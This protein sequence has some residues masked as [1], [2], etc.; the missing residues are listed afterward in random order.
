MPRIRFFLLPIALLLLAG[1]IPNPDTGTLV[2]RVVDE[3]DDPLPG[4][5]VVLDGT[6]LGAATDIDGAYRIL[7]VPVGEY[8]VTVS[9]VGYQP[10]IT[11]KVAIQH[12]KTTELNVA[13]DAPQGLDEI[14]VVYERPIIQRDAIG[15]PKVVKGEQI[16]NLPIRGSRND[17]ARYFIDGIQTNNPPPTDREGYAAIVE[18]NFKRP[19]D[20]PL[21]TFSIDV[22]AA[23]YA[24]VRR[25]LD[26]GALPVKDAVRIEELIN[27][28]TYDY[29]DPDGAHPFAVVTEVSACP[30]A[31][32]HRLV[33]IGLQGERI[34]TEDLPPSNLVF[35]LDV[36]G[37]MDSPDKLPL[38][39]QGF[40]LLADNL[41]AQDRVGIVV[42]AGA[43][44]VV[45]EPTNDKQQ[46][47]AALD[48]L[49]AGGSTAGGEGIKL[50]YN[51]ARTHFDAEKNNRVILA[52]DGD[53]NVGASSDAEMMRLIE[54]QRDSGVF[55][56]VLGFG[57]GNLQDSKMETI[58]DHG[59][60]HY[61]YIDSINEARKV[62]VNEMGGTLVTIAKDVK[63]QVEFNPAHVAAYRLIGYENRVLADEDFNDD[64]KDAGELGAGHSVTALYEIVPVGVEPPVSSVD[65]LKYQAQ[66]VRGDAATSP[67]LL[68][69]KLRYKPAQSLPRTRSGGDTSTLL[70]TALVDR[71]TALD[72]A[73]EAFRFSASVAEFG[74]LLRDSEHEGRASFEN[75]KMLA[76]GALGADE[77]GYRAEFVRLIDTA[78]AL[79]RAEVASR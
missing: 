18:N 61:A 31:P 74:L 50:A 78:D 21:S 13:L 25:F 9:F 73:S 79:A 29:P 39:K 40:R 57:T 70:E 49:Q 72:A 67:E 10:K 53:F 47:L 35:L 41:R 27:Y 3:H 58:A 55:L 11:E 54:A 46:I 26:G 77:H 52:T 32:D 15:A 37:S 5:N 14:T 38:L 48:M 71:G 69:V 60:G 19:T 68:T 66:R 4:A 16:A 56:S 34:D 33:H 65:P 42:Y 12:G 6:V 43:A 44:G 22:D 8:S 2:G 76:S 24:N 20:T 45:L 1:L 64:K 30:W 7:D 17:E 59:N 63:L 62:L 51:L 28:F 75:A 36:S 23:S